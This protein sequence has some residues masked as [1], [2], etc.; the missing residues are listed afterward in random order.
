MW[1]LLLGP[2]RT[3]WLPR[4]KKQAVLTLHLRHVEFEGFYNMS[5]E[6]LSDIVFSNTQHNSP[7]EAIAKALKK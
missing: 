5:Q 7:A 3:L 4:E 6:L 2:S 1:R